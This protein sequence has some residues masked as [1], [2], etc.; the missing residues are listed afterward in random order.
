MK[1]FAGIDCSEGLGGKRDYSTIFIMDKDC[2]QILQFKNNKTKPYLFADIVDAIGRWYNKA[3][4]TIEKASGGHR[5][6]SQQSTVV[7]CIPLCYQ[8]RLHQ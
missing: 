2:R 7:I 5:S 8:T 3:L 6:F 1:Y 4:L